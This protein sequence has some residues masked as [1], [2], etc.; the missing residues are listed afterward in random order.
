MLAPAD[1]ITPYHIEVLP[2]EIIFSDIR[3]NQTYEMTVYVKNLTSSAKRLRIFQPSSLFFRCD[4]DLS[5]S[6]APGLALK[7][8]IS[9]ETSKSGEFHDSLYVV[10]D[11]D[12]RKEVKL[13]AYPLRSQITFEPF[14]NL[15]FVRLQTE[16]T[17]IISFKNEGKSLGKVELKFDKLQNTTLDPNFF[18]M[19]PGQEVRIKMTYHPRVAGILKGK[20]EVIVDG[21]TFQNFLEVNAIAVEYNRFFIDIKGQIISKMDFGSCYYGQEKETTLFLVNNTPKATRFQAKLKSNKHSGVAGIERFITPHETG[22]EELERVFFNII[23]I[24]NY[25]NYLL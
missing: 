15:G 9:F 20:I 7:L 14:V 8:L 1:P 24:N 17:A 19:Q 5:K 25:I 10:S 11:K 12:F 16:K 22:I 23:Y 3:P 21:Q 18:T 6:L 13:H 2:P 4:Y